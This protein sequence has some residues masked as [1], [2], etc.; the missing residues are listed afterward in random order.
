MSSKLFQGVQTMGKSGL[1]SRQPAGDCCKA[2]PQSTGHLNGARPCGAMKMA[3]SCKEGMAANQR[4]SG[5]EGH[6]FESRSQQGHFAVESPLKCTL[7]LVICIHNNNSFVRRNDW[8]YIYFTCERCD[9]RSINK[10]SIRVVAT[11]KNKKNHNG[12]VILR[13][14]TLNDW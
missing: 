1:C 14:L 5:S 3:K 7:P 11:L 9:M 6:R 4:R 12:S 13:Q 10:K 8:L 2:V